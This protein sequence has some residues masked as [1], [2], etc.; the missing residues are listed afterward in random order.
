MHQQTHAKERFVAIPTGLLTAM[1]PS[2]FIS[3][4]LVFHATTGSKRLS[5][6]LPG[7]WPQR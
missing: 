7:V 5:W 4:G 6:P 3:M 1:A 2:M